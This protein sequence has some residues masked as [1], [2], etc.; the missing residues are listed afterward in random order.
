MA[1][2]AG[3]PL[4][5][6]KPDR[7]K[8]EPRSLA[9]FNRGFSDDVGFCNMTMALMGDTVAGRIAPNVCNAV[10]GAGR[11]VIKIVELKYKFGQSQPNGKKVLE[12]GSAQATA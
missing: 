4:K 9:Y 11:N 5:N 7:A 2:K 6:G 8:A 10:V 12:L 3:R 1:K